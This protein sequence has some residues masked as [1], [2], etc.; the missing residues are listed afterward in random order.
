[1][2]LELFKDNRAKDYAKAIKSLQKIIKNHPYTNSSK[3]L[4]HMM[5]H[6]EYF[7]HQ[8]LVGFRVCNAT[9]LEK[10]LPSRA[11]CTR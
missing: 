10:A 6:N 9:A 8:T 7:I 3:F 4:L 5:V 2:S 11:L 1:M